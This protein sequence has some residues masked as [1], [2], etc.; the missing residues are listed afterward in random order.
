VVA[1]G[2]GGTLA[3][4]GFKTGGLAA[5]RTV[6]LG[7]LIAVDK[8]AVKGTEEAYG[9]EGGVIALEPDVVV[10]GY[11]PKVEAAL[12]GSHEKEWPG[13]LALK[14][15]QQLAW[16]NTM[17]QPEISGRGSLAIDAQRFLLGGDFDF[18]D[19]ANAAATEARVADGRAAAK[20]MLGGGDNQ[21]AIDEL[22]NAL[23]VKRDGKRL[24]ASF[25]LHGTPTEVAN[26][27]GVVAALGTLLARKYMVETK[28][29]EAR[30]NV[31]K[32]ATAYA[33]SFAE[34]AGTR[35]GARPKKKLESLPPVPASVPNGQRYQS[36]AADW[37]AWTKIG[38]SLQAPQY[39]QYE[40]VAAKD[41]KSADVIA[42]GDLDADGELATFRIK[43]TLDAKTQSLSA[44]G[45]EENQPA[46]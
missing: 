15:G 45:L 42:K 31:P 38:F 4:I 9:S 25:E 18:A 22:L 17:A 11:Q 21:G 24:S 20:A 7:S 23:S 35:P 2:K 27:I 8:V 26:R 1:D 29:G 41:G 39:Y 34:P 3:L 30:A 28:S 33:A 46:E 19:E 12:E 13:T 32:I 14:P 16:Q 36:T 5:S 44:G 37:T 6:C 10:A 40:V 43:L